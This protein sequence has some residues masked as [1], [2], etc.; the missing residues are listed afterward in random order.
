MRF[1]MLTGTLPT[2]FQQQPPTGQEAEIFQ[3]IPAALEYPFQL[4]QSF[5]N[6]C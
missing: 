4:L 3:A 6:K 2:N 5:E 1:T